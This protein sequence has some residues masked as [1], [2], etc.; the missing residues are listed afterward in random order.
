MRSPW[1]KLAAGLTMALGAA[2]AALVPPAQAATGIIIAID[3]GHGGSDPGAVANGLKEK[4]L[5]LAVSLALKVELETYDGVNRVNPPLR[6]RSDVEA[7]RAALADGPRTAF[8]LVPDMWIDVD[9]PKPLM[10]GWG[11]TEAL[12][13][14]NHM[15]LIGEV[16]KVDGDE[17]ERWRLGSVT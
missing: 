1:R 9:L 11:L 16:T 13:Y 6:E 3:P 7:L 8:D 2:V 4:D 17:P 10:I 5:T 14:L 15:E 12:C